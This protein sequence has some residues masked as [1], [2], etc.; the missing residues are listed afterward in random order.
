MTYS[1]LTIFTEEMMRLLSQAICIVKLI[2]V[3]PHKIEQ[4]LGGSWKL[5]FL[6]IRKM[7]QVNREEMMFEKGQ[8]TYRAEILS[9][10][11]FA[12]LA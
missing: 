11:T 10:N 1:Y 12:V 4:S 8:I 3:L 9:Y 7:D 2:E 5:V 6:L